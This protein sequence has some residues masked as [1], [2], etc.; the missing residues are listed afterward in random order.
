M[1][2]STPLRL[3]SWRT[4]TEL[5]LPLLYAYNGDG[6]WQQWVATIQYKANTLDIWNFLVRRG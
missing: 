3:R 4:L 5:S 6:A 1:K 2:P